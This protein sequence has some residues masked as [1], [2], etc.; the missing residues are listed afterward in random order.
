MKMMYKMIATALNQEGLSETHHPQDYLNFYC[1]GKRESS[2]RDR[3][4]LLGESSVS[5]M[6]LVS[7]LVILCV[8]TNYEMLHTAQK[9]ETD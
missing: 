7:I 3:S 8:L 5:T 9:T 1:L 6:M 2:L 4:S